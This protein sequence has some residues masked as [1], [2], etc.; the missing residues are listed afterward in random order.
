MIDALWRQGHFLLE[1][2]HHGDRW[3][4]LDTLFLQPQALQ[5][6]ATA[7]GHL[8]APYRPTMICGPLT[9]GAFLGQLVA[10]ALGA[11]FAYTERNASDTSA[12]L[13]AARYALPPGLRERMRGER[14]AIVDD[15]INA[16]SAI[17]ATTDELTTIGA[18]V[19]AYGALLVL[20]KAGAEYAASRDLPLVALD[21]QESNLW[22]PENC[23]RC[24]TNIPLETPGA[25]KP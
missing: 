4:D 11:K 3:L 1:S 21:R 2:G 12:G 6:S 18:D 25:P 13:Y 14:V 8:L 17:R 23:P 7:L 22:I 9:G 24:A 19:V 5:S 15:I 16:G 10:I 20:G